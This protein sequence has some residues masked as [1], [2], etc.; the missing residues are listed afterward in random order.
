MAFDYQ[1]CHEICSEGGLDIERFGHYWL[2]KKT[3]QQMHPTFWL[4]D[5]LPACPNKEHDA[6]IEG[7]EF[8]PEFDLDDDARN[9]ILTMTQEQTCQKKKIV[10]Q[11]LS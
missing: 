9:L 10:Q 2:N 3:F 1:C 11:S 5:P 7:P 8:N 6:S 4:N